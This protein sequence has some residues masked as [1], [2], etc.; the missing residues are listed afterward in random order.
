MRLLTQD[1]KYATRTLTR[2]P[3]F[4]LSVILVLALGIGATTAIFSL[5][6]ATLLRPL[7]YAGADRLMM[8]WEDASAIG[9]PRNTPAPANYFDWR[10]DSRAFEDMAATV[11]VARNLTGDGEP[12]SLDAIRATANLA[13]VLG[14]EPLLGRFF[15]D[16]EDQPGGAPVAV[17]SHGLWQQRYGG[18][19]ALVGREIRLDD[20]PHTVVGVMGPRMS[21]PR[22]DVDVWVPMAFTDNEASRRQ[23]H[24]LNVV[25]RLHP[26]ATAEGAAADAAGAA[27]DMDRIAAAL[28]A[29]YPES[30][31]NVG[32]LVVP[33]E[34]HYMGDVRSGFLLLLAAVGAV[35]LI[36]CANIANL[37]LVRS[38]GR[39]REIAVRAALGA[40]RARLVRQM[41]TESLLLALAGGVVGLGFAWSSFEFL[42]ALIPESVTGTIGLAMDLRV[43]M[44]GLAVSLGTGVVFGI[45]PALSVS[46]V[47]LNATLQSAGGRAGVGSASRRFRD[48]LVVGEVALTVALL[49]G[50][51]LLIRSFASVRAVDPGYRPEGVLTLRMDLSTAKYSGQPERL[52]TFYYDV[53]ERVES[54][55]GVQSAGFVSFL[56]L[57]NRGGSRGLRIEGRPAPDPGNR[58]DANYR[59]VTPDYFRT[60]GIPVRRG[61]GIEDTDRSDAPPV[62]VINETMARQYWPGE[63][64][65]GRRI[66][67]FTGNA[68]FTIVGI[69]GDVRGMG[70]EAP[71]RAQL[72]LPV[73]QDLNFSFFSPR[74]LAIRASGDPMALAGVVQEEVWQVDPNQPIK[75]VR[76]LG[77]FIDDEVFQRRTQTLLLGAFAVLALIVASVGI[78]GVLS[79]AVS[80]LTREI[81]IRMALG[82]QR[83]SVLGMILGQGMLLVGIGCVVGIVLAYALGGVMSS[84]LF[85]VEATDPVTFVSVPALLVVVA[86]VASL[87][88][89][90]RATRVD[91]I[92][93]LRWE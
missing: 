84:M 57:T 23:S 67:G 76:L 88:P 6:D 52:R 61:R 93:A 63:D 81:G 3:A 20:A 54:L 8:I 34:D 89:A 15:T 18:D 22:S 60:M 45:V 74:N 70:L 85:G 5:V 12:L 82:A 79:Y 66:G 51:G 32:A 46:H 19:P 1:L 86:L 42:G 4:T 62:V 7:P 44:V 16:D 69:A 26:D 30:N 14:I 91:P 90:R 56:P 75:E 13:A 64:P 17:I 80:Y 40:G 77:A 28:E 83:G 49:V 59:L 38:S 65:I 48:V 10:A 43:L 11:S 9:F 73:D 87:I 72:Y 68:W 39:S 31:T 37:L 36:A 41:L 92:V 29:E 21:Y 78:Y 33:L 53:L 27:A 2:T 55:P 47:R 50:A 35:L 24:Y 25:G 71:V 58:P